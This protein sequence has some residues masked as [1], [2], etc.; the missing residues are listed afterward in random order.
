M[1]SLMIQLMPQ[2]HEVL[3]SMWDEFDGDMESCLNA[4]LALS[5]GHTLPTDPRGKFL[6]R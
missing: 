6:A 5:G 1:I 3:F 4:A 2:D